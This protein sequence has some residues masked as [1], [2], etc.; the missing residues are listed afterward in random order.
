MPRQ[1]VTLI[2]QLRCINKLQADEENVQTEMEIEIPIAG[3]NILEL[4]NAS[5][6]DLNNSTDKSQ[7]NASEENDELNQAIILNV[8]DAND[9]QVPEPLE[10]VTN[11][12]ACNQQ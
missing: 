12:G 7:V 1:L 11:Q 10:P 4:S 2:G 6:T 9:D 3:N 5:K 8:T